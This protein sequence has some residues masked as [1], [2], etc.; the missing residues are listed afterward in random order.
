MNGC[1]P[2][3]HPQILETTTTQRHHFPHHLSRLWQQMQM[4]K[5]GSSGRLAWTLLIACMVQQS[6]YFGHLVEVFGIYAMENSYSRCQNCFVRD[7]F[8]TLR[9][10]QIPQALL[11]FYSGG[12]HPRIPGKAQRSSKQAKEMPELLQFYCLPFPSHTLHLKDTINT[13]A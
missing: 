3:L 13:F 10:L 9:C 5:S 2:E 4:D 7:P 11:S 1:S 6:Q 8:F 12:D